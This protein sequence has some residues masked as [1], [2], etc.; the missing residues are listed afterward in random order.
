MLIR[1]FYF[2]KL[3]FLALAIMLTSEA[4]A[5]KRLSSKSAGAIG[6][7]LQFNK[8]YYWPVYVWCIESLYCLYRSMHQPDITQALDL[9]GAGMIVLVLLLNLSA[10]VQW[11]SQVM[12]SQPITFPAI[13]FPVLVAIVSVYLFISCLILIFEI[14]RLNS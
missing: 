5:I 4:F 3:S 6:I 13:P 7:R 11:Q 14:T 8:Q 10:L 1:T 12:L 9:A 2:Y